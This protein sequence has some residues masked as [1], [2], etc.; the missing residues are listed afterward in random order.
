ML[1]GAVNFSSTS[2]LLMTLE[3]TCLAPSILNNSP[4]TLVLNLVTTHAYTLRSLSKF[5]TRY[6]VN[7][8]VQ[9]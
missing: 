7:I 5:T 6:Y 2:S 3:T 4:H 1:P 8:P 9:V